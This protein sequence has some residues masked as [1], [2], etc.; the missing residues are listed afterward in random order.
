M[1]AALRATHGPPAAGGVR[2]DMPPPD[3]GAG[4]TGADARPGGIDSPTGSGAPESELVPRFW[5][6]LRVFATRRLNDAA[7]AEDVAQETLRRVGEA[8][9]AGRVEQPAALPGF[10]FQTARHV[11]LQLQRSAGREARALRRAS[12]GDHPEVGPVAGADALSALI[13]EERSVAVRR[14]L[15]TLDADDGELLRLAYFDQLSAEQIA[16]KLGS[17]AGAIR[18]R[19]HRAL[20]RLADRLTITAARNVITTSGTP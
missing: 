1:G 8:L 13:T 11:C 9:R 12:G 2:G 14:A 3:S 20:R 7:A 18:V 16:A 6:R 17:T 19:K 15:H 10:V 5:D 4:P